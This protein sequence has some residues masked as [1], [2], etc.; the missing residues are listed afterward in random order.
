MSDY[1]FLWILIH[2]YRSSCVF[3]GPLGSL[4]T[5][6]RQYVSL[7]VLVC[8]YC[9]LCVLMGPYRSLCVLIYLNGFL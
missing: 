8:P 3:M 1:E 2:S 5:F 7:W 4:M 9:F 6:M